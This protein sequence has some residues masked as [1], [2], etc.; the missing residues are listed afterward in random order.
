MQKHFRVLWLTDESLI[1]GMELLSPTYHSVAAIITANSWFCLGVHP[2]LSLNDSEASPHGRHWTHSEKK[3][4]GRIWRT[5]TETAPDFPT[6]HYFNTQG[7]KKSQ[8]NQVPFTLMNVSLI[9][10]MTRQS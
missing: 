5:F 10:L 3:L 6:V 2:V 8:S 9:E 1:I 7:H 4:M